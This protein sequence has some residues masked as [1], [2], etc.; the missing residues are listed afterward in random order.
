MNLADQIFKDNINKILSEGE[1]D[2]GPRPSYIDGTPANSKFITQVFETYDLSRGQFPLTSL[3]P[4]AISSGIKEIM[5]IYQDQTPSL[6]VLR[7]RYGIT[8]WDSWE[9]KEVPGTIGNRYGYTI[10]E[11]NQINN[12][13]DGIKKNPY[14]RR[15]IMTMW[16]WKHFQQTDGLFP[17]AYET[18]WSV[19]GQYLDMT[20]VQRSSDYLV[21]G[22]VNKIQYVAL[23]M[24]VAHHCGLT[25]GKFSHLVQNL[26]IYDRHIEQAKILL[27]RETNLASTPRLILETQAESFFDIESTEF[28]IVGYYPNKPQLKFELAI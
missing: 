4:I 26:H 16:D 3:R 15:H 7:E 23:Q 13:L 6:K 11:Y 27:E 10:R 28:S 1:W 14:S 25:P 2:Q 12:L 17:C 20:L 24:M 21:A 19:R 22:H 8:W 5:W 18:L 9:S